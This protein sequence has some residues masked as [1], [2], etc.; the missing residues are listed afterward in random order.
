MQGRIAVAEIDLELLL[1]DS[2]KEKLYRELFTFPSITYDAT[3]VVDRNTPVGSLLKKTNALHEF[4]RGVQ[5]VDLFEKEGKRHL[6]FRS[7]YNAGDRTL[8]EE[9]VKP[10]QEK[11]EAV[12]RGT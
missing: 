10:L 2:S 11:V 9:E 1:A 7:T 5:I 4:L 12:L 3:V 6:T 8:K